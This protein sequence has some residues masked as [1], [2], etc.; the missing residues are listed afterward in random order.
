VLKIG[1]IVPP[2]QTTSSGIMPSTIKTCFFSKRAW[3]L[4]ILFKA[5]YLYETIF[6]IIICT[7][8]SANPVQIVN[9]ASYGDALNWC[10]STCY[11][12]SP[13]TSALYGLRKMGTNS[14][15]CV[16]LTRD[17]SQIAGGLDITLPEAGNPLTTYDC[18][19][20]AQLATLNNNAVL[21][22]FLK[23]SYSELKGP[24]N[25]SNGS[26][27]NICNNNRTVNII[28]LYLAAFL[29]SPVDIAAIVNSFVYNPPYEYPRYIYNPVAPTP[30]LNVANYP[31][32]E[33]A[34][35]TIVAQYTVYNEYYLRSSKD[36][37]WCPDQENSWIISMCVMVL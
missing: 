37:N 19:V 13:S 20:D 36:N 27:V 32:I 2:Q 15:N 24:V 33:Q 11:W 25:N 12:R 8:P 5:F 14:Y 6:Y 22:D 28:T 7:F 29:G 23:N 26:F 35:W 9:Y 10:R 34:Y 17:I 21:M 3:L 31:N 4:M 18:N 30:P 1:K 16:C